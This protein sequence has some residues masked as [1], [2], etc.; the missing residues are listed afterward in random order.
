M[1]AASISRLKLLG[2]I[3]MFAIPFMIAGF[4]QKNP[5]VHDP[6]NSNRGEL[7]KP[8]QTIETATALDRNDL[9]F[10]KDFLTR[11]WFF[12]LWN[13]Q[14][15][16]LHCEANL[17]KIQQ[18][19]TILGR[20]ASRVQNVYL[21]S[22][23][24]DADVNSAELFKKYPHLKVARLQAPSPNSE[25]G[26][27]QNIFSKLKSGQVYIVDPLGNVIMYYAKDV[28]T[29]DMVKDIKWLIKASKI[30]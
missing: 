21:T 12:V 15:C 20:K 19:R 24:T 30:G 1:A 5:D 28:S 9:S 3:A 8:P 17:F 23:A 27:A 11:S 26:S 6:G 13:D 4:I 16:D 25:A 18:A 14:A 2:I 7:L 10:A 29:Q 22:L